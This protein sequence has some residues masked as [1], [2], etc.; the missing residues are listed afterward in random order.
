MNPRTSEAIGSKYLFAHGKDDN[1]LRKP[2]GFRN[3]RNVLSAKPG[4]STSNMFAED[5]TLGPNPSLPRRKSEAPTH[6]VDDSASHHHKGGGKRE[7]GGLKKTPMFNLPKAIFDAE[8]KR[9][10]LK[11][12]FY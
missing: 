7:G 2:P 9:G 5:Q 11:C 4:I 12:V 1:G 3:K 6:V 8:E 10:M